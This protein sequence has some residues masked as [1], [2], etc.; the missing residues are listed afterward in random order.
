[1]TSRIVARLRR[2]RDHVR[3]ARRELYAALEEDVVASSDDRIIRA[4]H[5]IAEW[6]TLHDSKDAQESHEPQEQEVSCEVRDRRLHR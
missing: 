3:R 1:M 5:E 2:K 4:L 6:R